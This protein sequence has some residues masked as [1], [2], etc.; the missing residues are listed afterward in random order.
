MRSNMLVQHDRDYSIA[1]TRGRK[2]KASEADFGVDD[3][4]A[5]EIGSTSQTLHIFEPI[6][7]SLQRSPQKI[8]KLL[9]IRVSQVARRPRREVWLIIWVGKLAIVAK[10]NRYLSLTF[11]TF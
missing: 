6:F 10:P 5:R 1:Y 7:R 3:N 2:R 4:L 8:F 9:R 11:K